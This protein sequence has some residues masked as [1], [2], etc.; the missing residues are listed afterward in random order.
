LFEIQAALKEVLKDEM[1]TRAQARGYQWMVFLLPSADN[2]RTPQ[3]G[4]RFGAS[5]YKRYR[6]YRL[7]I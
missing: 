6:V 3:M 5:I 7:A 2:P 4:V 1:L